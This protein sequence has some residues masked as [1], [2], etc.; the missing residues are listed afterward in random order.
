MENNNHFKRLVDFIIKEYWGE[1][2][3]INLKTTLGG[4]LKI[5]GD[6]G[7]EFLE[8]FLIH[9]NIDYDENREWQLHFDD[10]GFGLIN[11]IA[12]YNWIRRK[13]DNRD[14]YDLTIEHLIKIIELGYWIDM[15]SKK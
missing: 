15:K 13:K 5:G 9:F 14:Y 7:I 4:D 10:E 6:D 2:D 12:I 8:K 11:F 1:R 3:K